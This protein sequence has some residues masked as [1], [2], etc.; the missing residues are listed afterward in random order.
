MH[1]TEICKLVEEIQNVNFKEFWYGSKLLEKVK[2]IENKKITKALALRH[3]YLQNK[4][5]GSC[6]VIRHT[7][8]EM[9]GPYFNTLWNM[10][11]SNNK[12]ES[13]AA[14][15]IL[16]EIGG[17]WTFQKILN[18]LRKKDVNTYTVLIPCLIHLINRYYDIFEESDPTMQILD[19]KTN[20]VKTV[21]MKDYAPDI[22]RRT[23][24][25]RLLSN[26]FFKLTTNERIDEMN[27]ILDTIPQLY[28]DKINK[29]KFIHA[30]DNLKVK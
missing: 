28:Y 5:A 23:I 4:K 14:S 7:I 15:F 25:D 2:N 6:Y 13:E 19:V 17:V 8:K 27:S 24:T 16:A 22:Y 18:N 1:V 9:E 10:I 20:I 21:R 12:D 30:I 3:H 11:Y 29:Y 26:E